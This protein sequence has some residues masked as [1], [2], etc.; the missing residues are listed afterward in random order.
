MRVLWT[1]GESTDLKQQTLE[2]QNNMQPYATS[3]GQSDSFLPARASLK[4]A[5][6]TQAR[7][8][9]RLVLD[10]LD[11][12]RFRSTPT[13]GPAWWC[14]TERDHDKLTSSGHKEQ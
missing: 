6:G 3:K 11:V 12:H 1:R 5:G 14:I 10:I 7:R 9:H 8:K 13:F 4:Q 2:D